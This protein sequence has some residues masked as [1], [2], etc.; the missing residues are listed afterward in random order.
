[1][2]A[3]KPH[4]PGRRQKNTRKQQN[5]S[6]GLIFGGTAIILFGLIASLGGNRSA[7]AEISY[8]PEDIVT[9]EPFTAV[10]EMSP[11][12][13][14]S[15]NFLPKDGPQPK[16]AVSEAFYDFG[17][18]EGDAPLTIQRAYTTCGCTT[19]EFSSA[20]IPP[21][22]VV[23]MSLVLDAGFHDVRG[24]TVRRGVIIESNDPKNS[25]IEIWTQAKV[26]NQ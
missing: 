21:G 22:K 25:E 24:Q 26:R 14:S 20:V 9:A 10:H 19:A 3:R 2:P 23:V 13:V 16:I 4:K 12:T 18:I 6:I 1:M 17:S 8:Q 7:Q 5:L 11:S 15:I